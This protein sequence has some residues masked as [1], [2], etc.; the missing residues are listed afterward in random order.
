MIVLLNANSESTAPVL[1]RTIQLLKAAEGDE[2]SPL[3]GFTGSVFERDIALRNSIH[4][5]YFGCDGVQARVAC[6][7][8]VG[9]ASNQESR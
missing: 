9:H 5:P 1:E 8:L 6:D 7:R 2:Q 4:A 3:I